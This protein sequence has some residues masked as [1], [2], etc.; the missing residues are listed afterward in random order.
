MVG[1]NP[2][3]V[4]LNFI[5]FS[6]HVIFCS[7]QLYLHFETVAGESQ[8]KSFGDSWLWNKTDD[9]ETQRCSF[10]KERNPQ[11]TLRS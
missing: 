1:P 2:A 8:S 5:C 9:V 3:A 11:K 4:L 10:S 7:H 6:L